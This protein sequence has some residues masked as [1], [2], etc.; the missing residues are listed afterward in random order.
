MKGG[1]GGE[2][3]PTFHWAESAAA[4][5]V[6][7]AISKTTVENRWRPAPRRGQCVMHFLLVFPL[8]YYH[9]GA[10]PGTLSAQPLHQKKKKIGGDAL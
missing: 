4:P 9:P 6:M 5:S 7:L 1:L 8:Y 10:T 2:G 3:L